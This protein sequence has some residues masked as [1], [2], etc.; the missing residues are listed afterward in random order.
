[1]LPPTP[2][3]EIQVDEL[4]VA[5]AIAFSGSDD[6]VVKV[7]DE[8]VECP[9]PDVQDS[10]AKPVENP[11]VPSKPGRRQLTRREALNNQ[12]C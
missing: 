12:V 9:A 7:K 4:S 1:V 2:T 6:S 8:P 11:A 10:Q 3:K 5:L